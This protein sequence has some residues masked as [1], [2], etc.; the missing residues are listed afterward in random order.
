MQQQ[1]QQQERSWREQIGSLFRQPE[2]HGSATPRGGGGGTGL[3]KV[4]NIF[5][6]WILFS[7]EALFLVE[8]DVYLFTARVKTR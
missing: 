3:V 1:R 2:L 4:V 8:Y 5:L 6:Q 7:I